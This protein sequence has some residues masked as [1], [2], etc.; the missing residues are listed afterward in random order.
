MI[1]L[2]FLVVGVS[3]ETLIEDEPAGIWV[4]YSFIALGL[5]C[6]GGLMSGLTV[7]LMSIDEL[8]LE[9]KLASGTPTEKQQARKVLHVIN[10]HHLVL[11]TLLVANASAMEALPIILDTLFAKALS[12]MISVTFVMIVGEII[13]QAVCTGPNQLKIA[14]KLCP[15]VQVITIMFFPVSYPIAKLL[16]KI[17]GHESVSKKMASEELKTFIGLH[18]SLSEDNA[19][20]QSGLLQGQIKIIHGAIDLKSEIVKDHMTKFDRVY[21]L[22]NDTIIDKAKIKEIIK[23][24][25]SRIPVYNGEHRNNIIGIL[26]VKEMLGLERGKTLKELNLN[27]RKPFFMRLTTTMLDLLGHFK[28]SKMHMAIV[29]EDDICEGIITMEDLIENILKTDILD[30][31]DYDKLTGF[32]AQKLLLPSNPNRSI[33]PM[34]VTRL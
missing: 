3:A 33:R 7:G 19:K 25:Y 21:C 26:M 1:F 8:D 4:T 34:L 28:N 2:W 31:T 5:V 11:V 20:R 24:G 10:R 23:E 13:P 6:F 30:E 16:D 17:F 18:R 29:K 32:V 14:Y 27:L 15:L 12:I 22:S 9:L